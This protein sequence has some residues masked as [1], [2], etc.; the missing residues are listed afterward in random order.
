MD[1]ISEFLNKLRAH[2]AVDYAALKCR[3]EAIK[4]ALYSDG[5]RE[6]DAEALAFLGRVEALSFL[7]ERDILFYTVQSSPGV[8]RSYE[9][10]PAPSAVEGERLQRLVSPWEGSRSYG[11]IRYFAAPQR[12]AGMTS[13]GIYCFGAEYPQG[14]EERPESAVWK[15][16]F[17][18]YFT[19]EDGA[20]VYDNGLWMGLAE[21]CPCPELV[22]LAHRCAPLLSCGM[23]L[24]MVGWNYD[25]LTGGCDYKLYFNYALPAF[26]SA[27]VGRLAEAGLCGERARA[28][29]Y[30]ERFSAALA[31]KGL[32]VS[33]SDAGEG[34]VN[35]Y[36]K[37]RSR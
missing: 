10:R 25:R 21:R 11:L 3:G 7:R 20:R 33:Q 34:R 37:E 35:F 22:Q 6:R 31:C 17:R 23:D 19:D 4:F 28:V 18:T 15:I 9:Y 1:D 29:L 5:N 36:F 13:G 16:Y 2:G 8:R 12:H 24:H 30:D 14:R 27:A 32:A 26:P